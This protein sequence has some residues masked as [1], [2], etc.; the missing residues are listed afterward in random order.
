MQMSKGSNKP[1]LMIA[2]VGG[3]LSDG[4]YKLYL[5]TNNREQFEDSNL[6]VS[7]VF[8]LIA[9]AFIYLALNLIST[10]KSSK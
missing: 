9:A 3:V 10:I 7:L 8:A 2:L 4:L 6:L 5:Y 1:R